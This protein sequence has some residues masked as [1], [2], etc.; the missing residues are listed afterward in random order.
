[1]EDQIFG[2]GDLAMDTAAVVT[3]LAVFLV[4]LRIHRNIA[5]LLRV[6][7]RIDRKTGDTAKGGYGRQAELNEAPL[8]STGNWE[9][10]P[11]RPAAD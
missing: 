1:M 8:Q 6:I 4:L 7:R 2:W 10:E 11:N 5:A 9:P 3:V